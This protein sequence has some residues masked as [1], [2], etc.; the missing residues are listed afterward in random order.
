M[1]QAGRGLLWGPEPADVKHAGHRYLVTEG[2]GE[3][4]TDRKGEGSTVLQAETSERP[5][6]TR[7]QPAAWKDAAFSLS[8]HL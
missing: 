2:P 4:S 5:H 6:T 8:L 3:A 1:R 7:G